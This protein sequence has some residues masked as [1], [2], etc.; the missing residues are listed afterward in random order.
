MRLLSFRRLAVFVLAGSASS[1]ALNAGAA[2]APFH[3]AGLSPA[4]LFPVSDN[5]AN[6]MI[7]AV[8][9]APQPMFRN[10]ALPAPKPET[11]DLKSIFGDTWQVSDSSTGLAFSA[12]D[13]PSGSSITMHRV[14][15]DLRPN[16]E[17][18]FERLTQGVNFGLAPSDAVNS[19]IEAAL[20]DGRVEVSSDITLATET[21]PA[22]GWRFGDDARSANEVEAAY[23]HSFSAKVVDRD[24]FK[25]S[26][27]GQMGQVDPRFTDFVF[28]QPGDKSPALRWSSMATRMDFGQASLSVGYD[29]VERADEVQSNRRLTLGFNQSALSV[30]R[31]NTSQFSLDQGGHWNRR[32]AV[33]GA[34]ADVI[35]ADVLPDKVAEALAPAMPFMPNMISASFEEG[36]SFKPEGPDTP[37][38]PRERVRS[39]ST[40]LMWQSRLGETTA[41]YWTRQIKTDVDQLRLETVKDQVIDLAHSVRHGNWRFGGGV[42]FIESTDETL[43]TRS[44]QTRVAPHL[45]VAYEAADFATIELRVGAADANSIVGVDDMPASAKARQLQISL[46]L[47][48][49]VQ[50]QLNRP[51][52]KL[53]LEYRRELDTG[54]AKAGNRFAHEGDQALLL[55][56]STPLN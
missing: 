55:T 37:G 15:L 45:S 8:A 35:V 48:N 33:M 41:S 17:A 20:F 18:S 56:F 30:Y 47:S 53:K 44:R 24:R 16:L 7:R 31:R 26:L 3:P 49:F 46:D 34:N 10:F 51:E 5:T 29:D 38:T 11:L 43:T 39:V 25:W 19:G 4:V 2:A 32:T 54:D 52:A 42:S 1:L 12:L 9:T 50:D 6:S 36:D 28:T 40:A 21:V 23:Q 13:A 14:K 27:A 22:A